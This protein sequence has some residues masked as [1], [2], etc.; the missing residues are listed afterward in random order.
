MSVTSCLKDFPLNNDD[1]QF[2]NDVLKEKKADGMTHTEAARIAVQELEQ[3]IIKEH[4]QLDAQVSKQGGKLPALVTEPI[5]KE[6]PETTDGRYLADSEQDVPI[7]KR[8]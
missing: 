6:I 5:A 8:D 4:E 1:K 7:I 3:S 2:F